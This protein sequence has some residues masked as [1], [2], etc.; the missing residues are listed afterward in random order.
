M[1]LALLQNILTALRYDDVLPL[2]VLVL[3][4]FFAFLALYFTVS[5]ITDMSR[6]LM[7][8]YGYRPPR[9][10]A[11]FFNRTS[12][13]R[14]LCSLLCTLDAFLEDYVGAP[15]RH[16]FPGKT[17]KAFAALAV[18]ICT[19]LF[20]RA[21]PSMLLVAL[22]LLLCAVLF[23]QMPRYLH[24]PRRF[25]LRLPLIALSTLCISLFALAMML[26]NPI[27]LFAL[28]AGAF[29]KTDP[30]TLYHVLMSFTYLN[31]LIAALLFLLLYAP[32]SRYVPRLVG[33]FPARAQAAAH[34]VG[35]LVTILAFFLALWLLLPQFPQY[36]TLVY[37]GL[38]P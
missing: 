3:A 10:Q 23:A 15:L 36:D 20:Y 2:P 21:H 34:Y 18:C 29:K 35:A 27:T 7:T 38:I 28:L 16:L 30:L 5:G 11:R 22:P 13:H 9:G 31:H 1:L 4:L 14:M 33:K 24:R 8:M 26:D 17:G 12:P 6:G 32:L 37:G 25:P 19:V